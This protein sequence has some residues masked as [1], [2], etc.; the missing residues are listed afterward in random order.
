MIES[1]NNEKL[2]QTYP[3]PFYSNAK[4]F[5]CVSFLVRLYE[6]SLVNEKYELLEKISVYLPRD[7]H[8]QFLNSVI[9]KGLLWLDILDTSIEHLEVKDKGQFKTFSSEN[10]LLS[11]LYLWN[12]RVSS[13]L[14]EISEGVVKI[15]ETAIISC[16]ESIK[17]FTNIPLLLTVLSDKKFFNEKFQCLKV[18]KH[19][20]TSKCVEVQSHFI[21]LLNNEKFISL[22]ETDTRY[23]LDGWFLSMLH[24]IRGTFKHGSKSGSMKVDEKRQQAMIFE[25]YHKFGQ[26]M[27]TTYIR[28]HESAKPMFEEAVFSFLQDC[29]FK[30][31]ILVVQQNIEKNGDLQEIQETVSM[32]IRKLLTNGHVGKKPNVIMRDICGKDKLVIKSSVTANMILAIVETMDIPVDDTPL[33]VVIKQVIDSSTVWIEVLSASGEKVSDVHNHPAVQTVRTSIQTLQEIITNQSI[34]CKFLLFLQKK[35]TEVHEMFIT[36]NKEVIGS[37]DKCI[38]HLTKYQKNIE[39]TEKRFKMCM[40]V[41]VCNFNDFQLLS[42]QLFDYTNRRKDDLLSG[43]ITIGDLFSSTSDFIQ[44]EKIANLCTRVEQIVSTCV[45]WNIFKKCLTEKQDMFPTTFVTSATDHIELEG[46]LSSSTLLS[47]EKVLEFIT[48]DCELRY[49]QMWSDYATEMKQGVGSTALV[50]H[51]I[52]DMEFEIGQAETICCLE[53]PQANRNSLLRFSRITDYQVT[54]ELIKVAAKAFAFE[55]NPESV[56]TQMIDRFAAMIKGNFSDYEL[57]D[58]TP[59]LDQVHNIRDIISDE[60]HDILQGFKESS[61][62]L[63]FLREVI[64]DDIRNLIDSVE[65]HSEQ[66][67]RES[68]VSD[69]IEIKRFFNPVLKEN[70]KTNIGGLIQ[71]LEKQANESG[72][73]Q[74]R[75]KMF[76]C[77]E[78]L[79]S[80]RALYRNVANRGE[81]TIELIDNIMQNGKFH[82]RL[83][84]RKCDIC[85]EYEPEK[86]GYSP[87]ASDLGDLRSRALLIVNADKKKSLENKDDRNEK[88]R[89]FIEIIDNVFEVRNM[90]IKL[91]HAGHFEYS[92][93]E[94]ICHKD[95]MAALKNSL[96]NQFKH[97]I[98]EVNKVREDYYY[99]NFLLSDQLFE[100]YTYLNKDTK[101]ILPENENRHHVLS[102]YRMFAP[103]KNHR[104]ALENIGKA[105]QKLHDQIPAKP[106]QNIGSKTQVSMFEKVHPGKPYFAW[107]DEGSTLVI[108]TL[109]ALYLNTTQS[110]PDAHQVLFCR[111]DTTYEEIDLLCK[112]CIQLDHESAKIQLY[113]IVNVEKLKI[114]VQINLHDR[115]RDLPNGFF[116]LCLI[117]RG[118]ENHQF[119]DQ[120]TE[121]FL[122]LPPLSEEKTNSCLKQH[123]SSVTVV[124]SDVPGAGK[125]ECIQTKAI[126][127]N[128]RSICLHISGPLNR[129][130]IIED[131]QKLH[132]KKYHVLHIDIGAV[133]DPYQLDTFLFELLVL[134]Y[135]SCGPAAYALPCDQVFIEIAN[136]VKQTLFNSL[137]SV[138]FYKREHLKWK[139]Y[140]DLKVSMEVN[141]PIQVVCN[142]LKSL[143]EGTVD[144]QDIYFSGPKR[145]QPL[146]QSECKSLLK[147]HFNT[148]GDLSYTLVNIF[149][150]VL[151]D[152]LKKLSFSIYFRTESVSA[153]LGNKCIPSV[154]SSL[155]NALINIAKEFSSR[156]VNT[157][158]STQALT[159]FGED[160]KDKDVAQIM[161]KRLAG[162]IRWKDSNHLV[163]LFHQNMQT[164]SPFYRSLEQLP[165]QIVTLFERQMKRKLDN[166][167]E[168]TTEELEHLLIMLTRQSGSFLTTYQDMLNSLRIDYALTPDNL[169]KMVLISLRVNANIP[170]LIMGETGC[171]KTSL[172]RYL[173]KI[174]DVKFD[175]FSIHAGINSN[176]IR[177]R[178][179]TAN[180][181]ARQCLK[182]P[183]WLFWDEVNTC[184]H[185]GLI[186]SIVC[187]RFYQGIQLSPNLT[188]LAACNPYRLQREES[189][190]TAG[191][192]G[193]IKTDDRSKLVYRV[194]PLPESLVDFVWDYGS[195]SD[196]DED[197]YIRKMV[198]TVEFGEKL[199]CLLVK[200]LVMSQRFVRHKEKNEY[201]VSL[202]DVDRCRKL[203]K[204]IDTFLKRKDDI[205]T[206]VKKKQIT[207]SEDDRK[208]KSIIIGLT[209]CYQ[210]RFTDGSI[211]YEYRV[212]LAECINS[213]EYTNMSAKYIGDIILNEQFD[214]VSR[215]AYLPE[216]TALN[217]ALQE[218]VFMLLVCILCKVPIFLVGKPGCSK[219]LSIQL[220]RSNLRGKDSNDPLFQDMPQLFCVSF[221]GSESSTSDGIMKVFEK[222]QK[223]QKHND[224][225]DVLSVVILDEIGPAEISRFN[226]LKVL[227]GLLEP[228]DGTTLKIAVVGISNWALDAAKMNRA[229]HLSRP[230]MDLD[231]LKI[232]CKFIGES[233]INT[234]K[235]DGGLNIP[236]ITPQS[237]KV[238]LDKPVSSML[239]GIATA[240]NDYC[241][242]VQKFPNF[243]GLRDFYSLT[244][245]VARNMGILFSAG[246]KEMSD[247]ILTGILRNFGGLPT[248]QNALL[249]TFKKYLPQVSSTSIPVIKLIRENIM[250]KTSRH[251]MLITN[252]DVVISVLERELYNMGISFDI[253]FGSSFEEDLCDDYNYRILSRIIV[254]MGQGMVLILKDLEAIYGSLYDML[255]QNYTVI[256]N[257]KNCRVALGQY[258]NPMCHVHDD[259]KCIVLVEESRLDYSDPPFLNRFEKQHFEFKDLI[260]TETTVVHII[261]EEMK[262]FCQLQNQTFI[263]DDIIPTYSEDLLISL[264]VR[265][266]QVLGNESSSS[267]VKSFIYDRL[268]WLL[269]PEI[270][271]R[272]KDSVLFQKKAALVGELIE[273]FMKLPIHGGISSLFEQL[274]FSA[275]QNEVSNNAFADNNV[276][277]FFVYTFSSLHSIIEDTFGKC[278]VQKYKMAIFKSEKQLS[279]T[280]DDFFQSLDNVLIIQCI[281]STEIQYILLSKVIIEKA[282]RQ[283]RE[284]NALF[285]DTIKCIY[286]VIHLDRKGCQQLPINFLSDWKLLY[287]DTIH[288]PSTSLDHFISVNTHEIV[289]ERRPLTS[290][291]MDSLFWVFSRIKFTSGYRSSTSLTLVNNLECI[292]KSLRTCDCAIETLE[293]LLVL[294]IEDQTPPGKTS[295]WCVDVAKNT[296]ELLKSGTLIG[297]LENTVQDF[298]RKPL[299]IFLFKMIEMNLLSPVFVEDAYTIPRRKTWQKYVLS[300]KHFDISGI[301]KPSGP[302]CYS[303]SSEYLHLKMPYS[304]SFAM[305][306]DQ[307]KMDFMEIIKCLQSESYEDPEEEVSLELFNDTIKTCGKVVNFDAVDIDLFSYPG[308]IDDYIH[309]FCNMYSLP[310]STFHKR[311]PLFLWALSQF[312]NLPDLR[313][314]DFQTIFTTLHASVWVYGLVIEAV[315]QMA[316]LPTVPLE[317]LCQDLNDSDIV[318]PFDKMDETSDGKPTG[319]INTL[320]ITELD[321]KSFVKEICLSLLPTQNVLMHYSSMDNWLSIVR[322]M[323]P[324]ARIVDKDSSDIL[325][326]RLCQE[327]AEAFNHSD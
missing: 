189:I 207:L 71:M 119:L 33:E 84:K 264:V 152:Q 6:Q 74:V 76:T 3:F 244:K 125:T 28:E 150:R 81:H 260:E 122:R 106:Q 305:S 61:A 120:F 203:I 102:M 85:V 288:T 10:D 157:C 54:V 290:Y 249:G 96:Q 42:N 247:I 23:L 177:E 300:K 114:D 163:I 87:T 250:D 151:A 296:H 173:A 242:K 306:I 176:Q 170:V 310:M 159:I 164:V 29:S 91:N 301:P 280:I 241:S 113:S 98:A 56:Y 129:L 321:R 49:K 271:V 243:H 234:K 41:K 252:G 312:V 202:R 220:I 284:K 32:H 314:K 206:R 298:I 136:T 38:S 145:L 248:E 149:T 282:I 197:T 35:L 316:E 191:L 66:Y 97:W 181:N 168:K 36:Q 175:V 50:F 80:L 199:T 201:C 184:D 262:A 155:V 13:Q 8:L 115:L 132:L 86:N 257:K 112:R 138:A 240:Y 2:K 302:E 89:K 190:L 294:W 253:I 44:I 131:L 16:L 171:G 154:K 226:P 317:L 205:D 160:E 291:I 292:L 9:G 47:I 26:V 60:L 63:D 180:S 82:F 130:S 109:L 187:H 162:M 167:R 158:R 326:L 327:I 227:H 123:C 14:P 311:V 196:E 267:D 139:N 110:L 55:D 135:V 178:L 230:D 225:K 289:K 65:E 319:S 266:K 68:T 308:R 278:K 324:L 183:Y 140:D 77:R 222:A 21:D 37:L 272:G 188:L 192:Q 265:S 24:Y 62:L 268:L 118:N 313:N 59:V 233:M 111:E 137:P 213:M 141:S 297:A 70:F 169:L 166:F 25:V 182:V 18:M 73:I 223:Y 22:D 53:L 99:M 79:H 92:E 34:S 281:A 286:M 90:C 31:L 78:N 12:S 235:K 88:I 273:N 133:S 67:V 64:D 104:I 100:F 270:I 215:M 232:N 93:Y 156:S 309:D 208:L 144:A 69:L 204:W 210:S 283:L 299:A 4:D 20:S 126:L 259:F 39:T 51:E 322:R 263:P 303:C 57:K 256:G 258:S 105:L 94:K 186:T 276:H 274:Q 194:H 287:L 95:D 11:V 200:V 320:R 238:E 116:L 195:L 261:K 27:N 107:L 128:M 46:E 58:I 7:V 134:K 146:S 246:E 19:F 212:K 193:K 17:T 216:G 277:C 147:C 269:P 217:A 40:K 172:I 239:E 179:N 237:E 236:T 185:L 124:T 1:S 228:E 293:K 75:S 255:N 165:Q 325:S 48:D 43:K 198:G 45:F 318:G 52:Q 279:A 323:L 174:C 307:K 229:I 161:T 121:H 5:D 221:Q 275:N 72:I 83:G 295:Q 219:S 127:G 285:K 251:L 231:E 214:I 153:M 211:R 101:K 304:Q 254:C 117:C 30:A 143:D 224:E 108:R 103:P 142:Y 148:S 315:F 15:A 209:I 218:N 245:Y